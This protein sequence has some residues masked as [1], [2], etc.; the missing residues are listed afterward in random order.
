MTMTIVGYDPINGQFGGAVATKNIAVGSRVLR[1]I[2]EVGMIGFSGHEVQRLRAIRM[3]ELG[4]PADTVLEAIKSVSNGR[5]QYSIVDREG[6]SVAFTAEAQFPWAGSR[7]GLHYACG[8]NTMIGPGVVQ[9]LGDT[10]EETEGSGLSLHERLL[11]CLEAAQATG[12]DNRGRQ[13]AAIQ[14]HWKRIDANPYLDLRV[15]DHS[16]PIPELKALVH[17]YLQ[18]YPDYASKTWPKLEGT[19]GYPILYP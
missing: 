10:F 15:D 17:I 11:L 5:G 3:L 12:G 13:S 14:I 4:F 7:A 19:G 8:A 1:G 16:D 18:T 2:G 9:A 6:K